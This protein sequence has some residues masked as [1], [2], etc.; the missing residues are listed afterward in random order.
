[1]TQQ[2]TAAPASPATDAQAAEADPVPPAALLLPPGPP[3]LPLPPLAALSPLPPP[4]PAALAL[5][6]EPASAA[7]SRRHARRLLGAW[8]LATCMDT[9]QL[10]VSELVANAVTAARAVPGRHPAAAGPPVELSLRRTGA[11]LIIEVRDPNPD[12]PVAKQAGP[13]DEDG[14]GLLIV[15]TLSTRW[16][17]HAAGGGGKVVWCEIALP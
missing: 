2:A 10:L 1:M 15:E 14:R 5:P 9:V 13:Q 6:A 17:H 7:A 3:P 16:G 4:R 12:P 8:G 11:S